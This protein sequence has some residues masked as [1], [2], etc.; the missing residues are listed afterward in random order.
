M[1]DIRIGNM[2]N[3]Q[4]LE[5]DEV[6]KR[7]EELSYRNQAAFAKVAIIDTGKAVITNGLRVVADSGMT[8]KVPTG[9][10]IQR[11]IDTVGGED[12]IGACIQPVD[13]TVTMTAADGT[14]RTDIIECQIISTTDKSDSV[15]IGAVATGGAGAGSVIITNETIDRDIKYSLSVRKQ[16][17]TSTATVATAGSVTGLVAIPGTID[18]SVKNLIRISDGEDGDWLEI[19]CSGGTP[20]ATTRAE[21]ISALNAG[22][23]RTIAT[24]GAGNTITLT[25]L[26]TGETSYFSIKPPTTDSDADAYEEIFGYTIAG[27]YQYEYRGTNNWIKLAEID[28]GAATV[29]ITN[30]LIRTIDEKS[31]WASDADNVLIRYPILNGDNLY[32]DTI[33]KSTA[34][35][36]NINFNP[37]IRVDWIQAAQLGI[38]LSVGGVQHALAGLTQ[39]DIAY[40]DFSNKD[41]RVYRWD[42]NVFAQEGSDLVVTD[43]SDPSITALTSSTIAFVDGGNDDLRVYSFNGTIF[44]QVGNGLNISGVI[45]PTIAALRSTDIAFID[46]GNGELRRYSWDGTDWAMVGTGLAVTATQFYSMTA[47]N[48]I[49][50]AIFSAGLLRTYEWNI[51]TLSWAQVGNSLS[52]GGGDL[53]DIT[54]LNNTDIGYID[55]DVLIINRWDGSDWVQIG[56]DLTISGSA[57]Q[58]ALTTLNGTDL[59]FID[60]N[61]ADLR[62]YRFSYS[63]SG[64]SHS[65]INS[66]WT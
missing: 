59:A 52:T 28:I 57:D 66:T 4:Q 22:V 51:T 42:G 62:V 24:D 12:V 45:R 50:V 10:L 8:V 2:T 9:T 11:E 48:E 17:N 65:P 25:G 37:G 39:T 31:T 13:Q 35:S 40:I 3:G 5:S 63:I 36:G 1:R 7:F 14:P 19:D 43:I 56:I 23:G 58:V 15:R 6:I 53:H 44:S 55:S 47:L 20:S 41:L 64:L 16:T 60:E 49:T 21:I 34:K 27:L 33:N 30:A 26:G 61:N 38:D 54:A 18:L 32:V 29:T 46:D